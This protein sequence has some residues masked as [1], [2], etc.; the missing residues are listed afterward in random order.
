MGDFHQFGNEVSEA[1]IHSVSLQITGRVTDRLTAYTELLYNP[2]QNFASGSTITG[3]ARNN[4]NMRRAY[5]L[6]GDL[7]SSPFYASIGTGR[8]RGPLV[9]LVDGSVKWD[10]ITGIGV[11]G[12]GHGD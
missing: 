11:H 9:E 6:Y 10:M 4:V 3:L 1:V 8:G 2:E 5:L 12:F 7:T